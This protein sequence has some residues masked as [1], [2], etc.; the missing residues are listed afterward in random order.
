[1]RW[2]LRLHIV[3]FHHPSRESII[4]LWK[5]YRL[6]KCWRGREGRGKIKCRVIL[7]EKNNQKMY[8]KH[9]FSLE[10]RIV[11]SIRQFPETCCLFYAVLIRKSGVRIFQLMNRGKERERFYFTF[12]PLRKIN[13]WN[14]EEIFQ[15]SIK[16]SST[17]QR[18][19]IPI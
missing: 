1:M 13:N 19:N 7:V 3:I 10:R 5:L 8:K 12:V 17:N 15:G 18:L 16:T 4:R 14:W 6:L 11:S 2:S 9:W